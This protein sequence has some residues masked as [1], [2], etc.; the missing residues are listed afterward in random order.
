MS[1]AAV[2]ILS[3]PLMLG[4]FGFGFDALRLA[5]AKRY[6]QGRV[7]LATQ[8]AVAVTYTAA[9]GSLVLGAAADPFAWESTAYGVYTANTASKRNGENGASSLFACPAGQVTYTTVSAA[10]TCGGLAEV[11]GTP[12]DPTFDYCAAEGSDADVLATRDTYGVRYEVK[13]SVPTVFL[14][15]VGVTDMPFTVSSEALLRQSNC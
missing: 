3:L 1:I 10:A 8:A 2:F 14:H 13:E 4:A 7:D 9:D 5:Y 11:I 12:P 15:F 6:A